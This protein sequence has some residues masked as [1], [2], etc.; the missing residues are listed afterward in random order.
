MQGWTKEVGTAVV[1]L[2]VSAGRKCE[3]EALA[4]NE[5]EREREAWGLSLGGQVHFSPKQRER[6]TRSLRKSGGI[7]K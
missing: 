6:K 5:R 7:G 4:K 2:A 1:N 3:V